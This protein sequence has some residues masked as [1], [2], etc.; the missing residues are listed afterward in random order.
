MVLRVGR[1][2]GR[3]GDAWSRRRTVE[4]AIMVVDSAYTWALLQV[5]DSC[6]LRGCVWRLAFCDVM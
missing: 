4:M 5:W 1:V 2:G 6:F 3:S